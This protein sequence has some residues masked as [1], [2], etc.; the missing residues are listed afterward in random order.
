MNDD[1]NK[2]VDVTIIVRR[3]DISVEIHNPEIATESSA[4]TTAL[5]HGVADFMDDRIKEKKR[6]GN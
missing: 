3:D 6:D 2:M 1:I 5:L 4:V